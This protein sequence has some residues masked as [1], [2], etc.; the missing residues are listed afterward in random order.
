[1]GD[2]AGG[3]SGEAYPAEVAGAALLPPRELRGRRSGGVEEEESKIAQ[4]LFYTE[5]T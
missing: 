5:P 1:M 3:G 4:H 2:G